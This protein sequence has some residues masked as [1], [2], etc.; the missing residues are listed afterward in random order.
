MT[1]SRYNLILSYYDPGLNWLT[2]SLLFVAVVQL[3][4]GKIHSKQFL[5]CKIQICFIFLPPCIWVKLIIPS[6]PLLNHKN[7]SVPNISPP[8]QQSKTFLPFRVQHLTSVVITCT[9]TCAPETKQWHPRNTQ[10]IA[11]HVR[12]KI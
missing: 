12:W 9:Y 5:G 6:F 7:I 1:N 4:F 2:R 11:L 3:C 10:Q 8:P